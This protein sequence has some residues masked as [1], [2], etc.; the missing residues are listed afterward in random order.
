MAQ[1]APSIGTV[2]RAR[3]TVALPGWLRLLLRNPKSRLG[4]GIVVFMIVIALIAPWIAKSN[5]NDYTVFGAKSPGW[6]HLFGTTDQGQD[7]FS[8]VVLGAR[9]SL[10]LGAAA[11]GIA[12]ILATV[13]GVF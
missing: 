2:A 9:R 1:V 4:L 3:R 8:E 12:T 10:L 7:I 5:A 6:G 13:F 11:G